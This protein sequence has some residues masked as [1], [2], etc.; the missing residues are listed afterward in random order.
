MKM[1]T[2][3]VF[4]EFD[5]KDPSHRKSFERF[6][7]TSSWKHTTSRFVLEDKFADV[8]S[9]VSRKLLDFYMTRDSDLK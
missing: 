5:P 7:A 6:L 8:P 2:K 9:M 4:V 1:L 3:Q